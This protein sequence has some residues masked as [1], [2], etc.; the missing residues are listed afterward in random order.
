MSVG[1]TFCVDLKIRR[2]DGTE[3][4]INLP[5]LSPI[6]KAFLFAI[7][8]FPLEFFIDNLKNEQYIAE[9]ENKFIKNKF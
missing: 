3:I 9:L 8:D 1:F 5:Q 7:L 6:D 2:K 4:S